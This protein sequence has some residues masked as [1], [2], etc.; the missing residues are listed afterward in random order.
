MKQSSDEISL[1]TEFLQGWNIKISRVSEQPMT[2]NEKHYFTQDSISDKEATYVILN[3][4]RICK[5][6]Y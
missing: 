3:I 6:N 2:Q 5:V 4:L 1:I